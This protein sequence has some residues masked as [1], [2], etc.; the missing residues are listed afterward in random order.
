MAGELG[1]GAGSVQRRGISEVT[2][3]GL[4]E[5]NPEGGWASRDGLCEVQ[6]PRCLV[7]VAPSS[8]GHIQAP[9][10][11]PPVEVGAHSGG[12]GS[13]QTLLGPKTSYSC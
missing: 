6:T 9:E 11:L 3:P 13:Q 8:G 1:L 7:T 10:A 4:G 5:A 2:A 12:S